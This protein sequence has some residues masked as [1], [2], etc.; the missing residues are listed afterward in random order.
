LPK[1]IALVFLVSSSRKP[2][3]MPLFD[4][5]TPRY[6]IGYGLKRR[7]AEEPLF[8]L[9]CMCCVPEFMDLFVPNRSV[10][11]LSHCLSSFLASWLAKAAPS[12]QF[13]DLQPNSRNTKSS[14]PFPN[15]WFISRSSFW[16]CLSLVFALHALLN[17]AS[18]IFFR[19]GGYWVA[20]LFWLRLPFLS[21]PSSDFRGA[22]RLMLECAQLFCGVS[23]CWDLCVKSPPVSALF[24]HLSLPVTSPRSP[25]SS[26]SSS[27]WSKF[28]RL[29]RSV[30]VTRLRLVLG[31]VVFSLLSWL[32]YMQ[33]LGLHH[34]DVNSH[35]GPNSSFGAKKSNVAEQAQEESNVALMATCI[36]TLHVLCCVFMHQG[37]DKPALPALPRR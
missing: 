3:V 37:I 23:L 8:L 33:W 24:S 30:E 36:L 29:V 20:S 28:V 2:R 7:G 10:S 25:S 11:F 21:A 4:V 32:Q 12:S 22:I 14:W 9:L 26:Y 5:F 1:N 6:I 27:P 15:S 35:P 19:A 16:Q 31:A 13:I 18:H 17:L 34:F